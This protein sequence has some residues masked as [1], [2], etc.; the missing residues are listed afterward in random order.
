MKLFKMK[1]FKKDTMNKDT[2][3]LSAFII[4]LSFIISAYFFP[5]L[6]DKLASHWNFSGEVDGYM[7]KFLGL[8]LMPMLALVMFAL[9]YFL[10]S[11]D[12]LK[13]NF[14]KFRKYYDSFV[15]LMLTFLLY[16]YF[17]TLFWNLGYRFDMGRAMIPAL[18][19]LFYYVGVLMEH[20]KTNWFVGIRTPW[21]LSSKRVWDKT[22][23][24][25]GKLYKVAALIALAGIFF[26]QYAPWFVLAPV[27]IVSAYLVL[28]SYLEHRK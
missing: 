2:I 28:Y 7:P 3:L 17:L 12:P 6:P 23:R 1:F 24:L 15:L 13:K 14:K 16:I 20:V 8:F 10:P 5:Q 21:T 11:I 19:I 22:H 26:Q 27:I 4:V 25:G 18:G 9:F